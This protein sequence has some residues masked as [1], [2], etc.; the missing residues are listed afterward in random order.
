MLICFS[1]HP[2]NSGFRRR[3][4]I[5]NINAELMIRLT[6]GQLACKHTLKLICEQSKIQCKVMRKALLTNDTTDASFV[7][8]RIL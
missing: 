6:M 8:L 4:N 2:I 1:D 5:D 7:D 3:D